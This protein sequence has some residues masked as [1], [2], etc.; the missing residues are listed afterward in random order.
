[1]GS[2]QLL[3][4][5]VAISAVAIKTIISAFKQMFVF[6]PQQIQIATMLLGIGAAFAFD[7][8]LV[9]TTNTS[10]VVVAMQKL[11]AGVFIGATSIGTHEITRK[12]TKNA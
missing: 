9:A 8:N 11:F 1:M 10:V 5:N 3:I 2:E 7:A 6:K 12:I 4:G